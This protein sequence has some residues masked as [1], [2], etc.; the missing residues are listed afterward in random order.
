MKFENLTKELMDQPL[1][2]RKHVIFDMEDV[3]YINSSGLGALI[4]IYHSV[5]GKTESF[6][7]VNLQPQVARIMLN[8]QL[9]NLLK[10]FDSWETAID[11][12]N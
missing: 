8:F 12:L 6:A 11:S 7:V 5:R 2:N 4:A 10:Y 1:E 3:Y 9:F